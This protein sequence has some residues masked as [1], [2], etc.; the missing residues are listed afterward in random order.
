MIQISVFLPIPDENNLFF[1]WK[2]IYGKRTGSKR[3]HLKMV[4]FFNLVDWL[5]ES[6]MRTVS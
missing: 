1:R 2:S 3:Y 6:Q 4:P 5:T